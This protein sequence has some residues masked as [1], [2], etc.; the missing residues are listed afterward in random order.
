MFLVVLNGQL[1]IGKQ[2]SLTAAQI[3][4]GEK[5]HY[6]KISDMVGFQNLTELSGAFQEEQWKFDVFAEEDSIVAV[7]PYGEIKVEIRKQAPA[8][9]KVLQLA[10]DKAFETSYFNITGQSHNNPV[11]FT[12]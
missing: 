4:K 1:R 11:K 2:Q 12:H 5:I 3:L 9:W 6:L 8:M 7:L 10:A